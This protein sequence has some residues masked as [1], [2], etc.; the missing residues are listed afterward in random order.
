LIP[1]SAYLKQTHIAGVSNLPAAKYVLKT[2]HAKLKTRK[3]TVEIP[4][5]GELAVQLDLSRG[6][7]GVL[8]K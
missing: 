7:P 8:Y 5:N 3:K 2:W 6:T 1:D 4:A